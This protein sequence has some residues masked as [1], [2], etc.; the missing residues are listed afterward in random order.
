[1][2]IQTESLEQQNVCVCVQTQCVAGLCNVGVGSVLVVV[3]S[4]ESAD[5]EMVC[6]QVRTHST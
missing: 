6:W 3:S 5:S 2:L 4:A 1:M